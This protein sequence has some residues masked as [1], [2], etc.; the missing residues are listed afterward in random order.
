MIA[1]VAFGF[2]GD[3]VDACVIM[4]RQIGRFQIVCGGKAHPEDEGGKPAI[5]RI[6]EPA[7]TL[8]DSIPVA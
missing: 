4:T 7:A 1:A 6:F 5:R 2:L 3:V 8:G